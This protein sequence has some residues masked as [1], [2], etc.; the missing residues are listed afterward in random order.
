MNIRFKIVAALG[1]SLLGLAAP[2]HAEWQVAT[3]KH[4]TVYSDDTPA[5]VRAYTEKLEKFDQAVRVLRG[6]KDPPVQDWARPRIYVVKDADTLHRMMGEGSQNIGGFYSGRVTGPVSFMFREGPSS[7]FLRAVLFHEYTHH[8]MLT[9]WTGAL[10]PI[11]FTEGFAEFHATPIFQADGSV[12]FGATPT[13]RRFSINTANLMPVE[14]VMSLNPDHRGSGQEG[15]AFYARSWLLMDYLTFDEERRKDLAAY[16][17]AINSG[18]SFADAAKIFKPGTLTDIKLDGWAKRPRLPSAVVPAS[19]LG[20]VQVTMR[21]ATPAEAAALPAVIHSTIGVSKKTAPAAAAKARAAA[22]AFPDDPYVQNELAEAEYDVENYEASIAAA[23]KA[24]AGDAK[25]VHALVYRGM[26]RTA[27][28]KK[29]KVTDAAQW[30]AA[31][32]DFLAANK[33]EAENPW[34]LYQYYESFGDAGQAPTGNA[35][36]A[37][38]YAQALAPFDNR[39]RLPATKILLRQGKA[40]EAKAMI[41]P[42]AYGID[43]DGNGK[44]YAY[45][46]NAVAAMDAGDSAGAIKIISEGEA[47]IKKKADDEKAKAKS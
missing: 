24:V 1:A 8:I 41:G 33:I 12:V 22:A 9:G 21:V 18:Q 16:I 42:V 25:S 46:K 23:E 38:L 37:L 47:A 30:T 4:F 10:F 14:R 26:A 40:A 3:T 43:D 13:Y 35:E 28:L 29:A 31:R 20:E 17:G 19:K 5:A 15:G 44:D 36:N 27:L 2:A 11:W 32:R 6:I 45:L 34:P 7:D 39:L